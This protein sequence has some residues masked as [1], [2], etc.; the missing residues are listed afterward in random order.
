MTNQDP[1]E[2]DSSTDADCDKSQETSVAPGKAAYNIVSDTVTGVNVR[3]SDNIFQA[4]FILATIF[5]L[6]LVPCLFVFV[7]HLRG[8][9]GQ[10]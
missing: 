6:V 7:E 1:N 10:R 9:G 8:A 4:L 5:V 2:F 3:K